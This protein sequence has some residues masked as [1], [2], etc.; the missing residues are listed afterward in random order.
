MLS[1][2]LGVGVSLLCF[3]EGLGSVCL[4]LGDNIRSL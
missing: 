1:M 2:T 4:A 3:N